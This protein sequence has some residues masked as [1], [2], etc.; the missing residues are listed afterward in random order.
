MHPRQIIP[1][2]VLLAT[3][4]YAMETP[5]Q[6]GAGSPDASGILVHQVSSPYQANT[7]TIRILLPANLNR[8][9]SYPTIYVLPVEARN[10]NR[11]GDGLLEVAKNNLHNVYQAIFVAPTFSHLPWY[12][13]HPTDPQM[14]Q[15]TYLLRVVIPF[16]ERTYPARGE[17]DGRLLL[18]FSKSGWGAFGLLLRHPDLFGKA[19]SWDAPLMM[20]NPGKYG[21]GDIF[22]TQE[23]FE[24]YQITKLLE[25]KA[26]DLQDGKRLILLGYG[27]FREH[28][29]QLHTLMEKLRIEHV[30][31][32]GPQRKHDWHSGWVAPAV[33]LLLAT[34]R[35][36][37]GSEKGTNKLPG[38]K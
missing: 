1:L 25:R 8:P 11:Y 19:A 13:D 14:R 21:S 23:N 35:D 33:K 17:A 32:D 27:N 34:Q 16:I 4:L 6:V 18:G 20:D 5:I 28:H 22:A 26:P 3:T 9:R 12:A 7:T 15:E 30:Y 37:A 2:V 24:Q 31:E 10:E 36:D 38:T 29:Q